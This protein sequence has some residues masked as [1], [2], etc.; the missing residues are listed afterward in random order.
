MLPH[1]PVDCTLSAGDLSSKIIVRD[2]RGIGGCIGMAEGYI[3]GKIWYDRGQQ[4]RNAKEK[5]DLRRWLWQINNNRRR[6]A[7]INSG[8]SDHNGCKALR[9]GSS[10]P[11]S[12]VA[13]NRQR[14][15]AA[16]TSHT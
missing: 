3:R 14:A 10:Q 12:R 5:P 15:N 2:L 6:S 13:E 11:R 16:G 1:R 9:I 7:V 8:N 4:V